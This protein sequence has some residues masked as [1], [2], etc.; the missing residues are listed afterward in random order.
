MQVICGTNR[1]ALRFTL[2]D[3]VQVIV[4]LLTADGIDDHT[5]S[6]LPTWR[7]R[8]PTCHT[9]HVPS[10]A[11]WTRWLL[12]AISGSRR[13]R[14][15]C[16]ESYGSLI[17]SSLG[18]PAPASARMWNV[19]CRRGEALLESRSMPSLSTCACSWRDA[20]RELSK[21]LRCSDPSARTTTSP[22][23]E[24]KYSI[25]TIYYRVFQLPRS[26]VLAR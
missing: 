2:H 20:L 5:R 8:Q 9:R 13:R 25:K 7:A 23:T 6:T 26:E 22:H 18:S 10:C 14:E 1:G 15:R 11:G 16:A 3:D 21:A 12:A 19:M 4:C 17:N 24:S